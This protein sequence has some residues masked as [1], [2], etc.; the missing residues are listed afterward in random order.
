L[1]DE[2]ALIKRL[3]DLTDKFDH[4]YYPHY[5][6]LAR[7]I[8]PAGRVLELGVWK[9]GSL[10]LWRA[11]FPHGLIVGVDNLRDQWAL[12]VGEPG[13]SAIAGTASP[14]PK[15]TWP[16]GSIRVTLSQDDPD[17]A[18][19]AAE[20]S[21]DGYDLMVDDASHVGLL[22]ERS[23]KLLWPLVRAG[24]YYIVEDWFVGQ[25]WHHYYGDGRFDFDSMAKFARSFIGPEFGPQSD[26][27]EVRYVNT[28][29]GMAILKKG[30]CWMRSDSPKAG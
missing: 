4:G 17:L 14:E 9:G 22:S 18:G 5:R 23:F 26:I 6:E 19:Q 25:K 7:I 12:A 1:E 16:E 11:L 27:A 28:G 2:H 29:N 21:P 24:G 3:S 15:I 13:Q 8:G 10:A 30:R 20:A